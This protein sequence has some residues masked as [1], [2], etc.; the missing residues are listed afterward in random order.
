M[1]EEF[2]DLVFNDAGV[3]GYNGSIEDFKTLISTND[4]ALKVA[5]DIAKGKGY[6]DGPDSF[7]G[8]LGLE[9][10]RIQDI[11]ETQEVVEETTEESTDTTDEANTKKGLPK[12]ESRHMEMEEEVAIESLRKMYKGL[13]YTFEQT[14]GLPSVFGT[15]RGFTG[16]GWIPGS[17]YITVT[18]PPDA[19]G[20]TTSETFSFDIGVPIIG[21]SP[22][23]GSTKEA[24]RLNEWIESTL[25]R[26]DSVDKEAYSFAW[27]SAHGLEIEAKNEDGSTKSIDQLTA[28]EMDAHALEAYKHAVES[29]EIEQAVN[30]IRAELQPQMDEW[31]KNTLLP[32]LQDYFDLTTQ[33]GA[34][35][36]NKEWTNQYIAKF[37]ELLTEDGRIGKLQHSVKQAVASRFGPLIEEK[38]GEEQEYEAMGGTF[39]GRVLRDTPG[40]REVGK[41]FYS[42][43]AFTMPKS[44][45]DANALKIATHLEDISEEQ[46]YLQTQGY[47]NNEK[48]KYSKYGT[49]NLTT[50]YQND[51]EDLTINSSDNR[52]ITVGE[53]K[54]LLSR[55]SAWLS[56][57]LVERE[58][59][60]DYYQN[61]LDKMD[62][63]EIFGEGLSNPDL[64]YDDYL[65]M[66]GDQAV[67][68]VGAIV[69]VG[70]TTY[71][72]EAG[73]AYEEITRNKAIEKMFPGK[74]E[75]EQNALWSQLSNEDKIDAITQV[76]VSGDANLDYAVSVGATNAGLDMVGNS[77][78]L[79]S[80]KKFLPKD[81]TRKLLKKQYRE[82][83]KGGWRQVGKD[84]TT[85]SFA[86]FVTE[87]AQEA[88]SIMGVGGATGDFGNTYSNV[89]RM[90]EAGGQALLITPGFVG[91][92][93]TIST[94]I[95]E[96]KSTIS[97]MKDPE[98][99]R[100]YINKQKEQIDQDLKD[101]K[102]NQDTRDELFTQL[103]AAEQQ[104]NDTKLKDLEGDFKGQAIDN[105]VEQEKLNKENEKL[106]EDIKKSNKKKPKKEGDKATEEEIQLEKNKKKLEELEDDI[107]K[108]RKRNHYDNVEKVYAQ[109]INNDNQGRFKDKKMFTFKTRKQAEEW[110]KSVDK[111]GNSINSKNKG[112]TK[113]LY[114]SL[115]EQEIYNLIG[116]RNRNLANGMKKGNIA[117]V[118]DENVHR[119]IDK[120]RYNAPNVVHHEGLHFIFDTFTDKELVDMIE[121]TMEGIQNSTDPKMMEVALLM[122]NA[123]DFY[124][125]T[126][127]DLTTRVGKEEFF[128]ALS[129]AMR[130]I[131]LKDI[132]LD[133]GVLLSEIGDM[134]E[135]VFTKGTNAGL[136]FSLFDAENT[137]AFI[138]SYNSF[139]GKGSIVGDF[140]FSRAGKETD[141]EK[142]KREKD[143]GAMFS[144]TIEGRSKAVDVVNKIEQDIKQVVEA[145]GKEYTKDAFLG[146]GR[147]GF[148][149][150]FEALQPGGAIN[151]YIKSLQMS[152]EKTQKTIDAV[153]DRL[154][155]YDP[156][157]KRKDAADKTS[158]TIGEFLMA[159]V[160]YGK[161][162]AAKAL[163]KEGEKRK[164]TQRLDAK[165]KSGRTIAE[166]LPDTKEDAKPDTKRTKKPR[167]I[168]SLEDITIDNK[169]VISDNIEKKIN[170]LI[171]ENP[172]NLIE[173][174][175][176]LIS[177]DF[178]KEVKSQMGKIQKKGKDTIVS[179]EYKAHH[180]FNYD[181]YIDALD[182]NTIKNNYNQLFDIK[183]LRREK[184][185]KV[186]PITGKVTY[187]GKGIYDIS[188]PN[189]AEWTK[190]FT[191][192]GYTTLLARQKKLAEFIARDMTRRAINKAIAEKS[193]DLNQVILAEL[194]EWD[195]ALDKQKGETIS[196]DTVRFSDT[197]RNFNENE[198][199][200]FYQNLPSL[201]L[202][203]QKI[204]V[205][206]KEAVK[207]VVKDVYKEYYPTGKI[208]KM[209]DSIFKIVN[210][211]GAIE[212]RHANLKTKPQKTLNE[213]LFEEL[214]TIELSETLAEF[215]NLTD[216]KGKTLQLSKLFDELGRIKNG[217]AE[218]V[219]IGKNWV[220]RYGKERAL[221]ML[222][223]TSGM[224]ATSTKIGRGMFKVDKDGNV[225][226]VSPK[227][228]GRQSF[229]DQRYQFFE[230]KKDFNTWV[231][232]E[233]FGNEIQLTD[234]GR[235]KKI[236]EL[237][238]NG[239]KVKIDTSLLAETSKAAMS[240]KDYKARK[241]Q[242]KVS[243]Q[244]V[245]D[246]AQHYKDQI[247]K[248]KPALDK[249]DFAMMMMSMASNMQSPLKR[250]ANLGYIF[251]NKEGQK[252]TG[253]LRYE[254]MIPTNYMVMQITN[255]Y[256]NDGSVDLDA[257]FKEYTVAV[258][259][260]T[261]DDIFDAMGLTQTMNAGWRV[262]DSSTQRY[263]NMSTY[264]HPDLYAIESLNPADK[265][266][267]YGEAVANIMFSESISPGNQA[268]IDAIRASRLPK[269]PKGITV[270]DFDD[271]LA[272]TKSQVLFTAPD[273][274]KGKLTAEE[275]AKD[276]AKLLVE[277][278]T[279]DFSE[280]NQ[281]IDGKT[282]PLFKKALKL[283]SKFG[284]KNM[285]VLTARAPESAV[286]IKEFLDAQGLKIPLKN[287]TGLGNSTAD[288][289][290]AWI[291]EKVA[292]GYNDFYFAD[293]AIQNVKAVKN[294]LDQFDV[295]SK[296]QQA[297]VKFSESID[298][299]FNKILEE[300]TGIDA[301]KRFSDSKSRKRGKD[302]GKFR[303]F[304]PPSHEDFL[305]L[306]YNFMGKG[307]KGN[308][309]RDFF[310]KSLLKPLNRAFRELDVAK[311][312][313]AN[314]FKNLNKKF[315]KIK[316]NLKK[317]IP[318]G[319]FTFE[320]AI[321]VYLWDKHNHDI[322]GISKSDQKTLVEFVKSN[323]ELQAYADVLNKISK[324]D[325]YIAPTEGWE[326]GDIR[327][328]LDDATGRIGRK[329]FFEEFI[330]NADIIF[331]KENLNKIEAAFGK[332]V[333]EA[334]ED[335][336]HRIKTGQNR[337]SGS[338][339]LVNN[340]INFINGSVG[341]IMFLNMRSAI[342][343]QMSLVNFINFSDNN[344]LAA[345][346][347]FANQKQYWSDWAYIFNS[348]ML[349]QRRTGIKTDVNGAELAETISRSK[350]PMRILV[351]EL[352]RLGFTP[353]QIGDSIAIATG[354]AT[355]Y[356]NR[357]NS[358]MKDGL[359]QK[360]AEAKA[361]I[362]FQELA[363][364]TQQSARPDMVSQQQASPLGKFILAFQ[365]VTS[366]FNRL[367]KK[368]FLDIKNR[369]ISPGN[370]TQFQSDVSN[371]SRIAY[372]FAIQNLIFYMLQTALF[373][374][375]FDDD[376]D[377]ERMLKKKERA[378]NGS[379][380]SVL[381][382][383]GVWGAVIATLKNMG[384]KWHE[385]RDKPGY[386]KDEAAVLLE[387][388]NVSPPLGI[389]AR[390]IVNAEKTLN[391]NKKE[392][393]EMETFDID[394]PIWEASASYVQGV[395]NI[396]TSNLYRKTQ[397]VRDALNNK[398]SGFHRALMFSGWSKWNLGIDAED[399]DSSDTDQSKDKKK[400][401][402]KK[403]KKPGFGKSS[404][405]GF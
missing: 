2:L 48:L 225:Y 122:A 108:I 327:I 237:T 391:Y 232:K 372:Y 90:A 253:D 15:P 349:K 125:K 233:I 148:D 398:F 242:A 29:P 30:D 256:M 226:M 261:M 269:K 174:L 168:K 272:T 318:Q 359:S 54:A 339:A 154:I 14:G 191:E 31:A 324:Q 377:D 16:A 348:D 343:Q 390:K 209:A 238:I 315:P 171:E 257:L 301:E 43:A 107:F 135:S 47:D 21:G 236:Q 70:G 252:Y 61:L 276:G 25:D 20:N 298:F 150:I 146:S 378:I 112:K 287:I 277:G 68:I 175:E 10:G 370:K 244:V 351:R 313:I 192:G 397:N 109:H 193:N 53:R 375:M 87:T 189:K 322:P 117:V 177:K 381:R 270:L 89:K 22:F 246:I 49:G 81:L 363:E 300:I 319:D 63:P 66:F 218:I 206:D 400:T 361:W 190:Y 367:G 123:M 8:L 239:K 96:I 341:S 396:P 323:P 142:I 279:Y 60:S 250:A 120:G 159:N 264:G 227:D 24:N 357:V 139:N 155:N 178:A 358:Y 386:A 105:V 186:D 371:A 44:H 229:G 241:K 179:E 101:N 356:R 211:Y 12:V 387:M 208:N 127:R 393:E 243:E 210:R 164:V 50:Y 200:N 145:E 297:R 228:I 347:A 129:D 92:G 39:V 17:D 205:N 69:T 33:E 124:K 51:R 342:L 368:A 37:D 220:K 292:N 55:R 399:T 330:H 234:K 374:T 181:S 77:I 138:Q 106:E 295:K 93:K 405:P 248:P 336:L 137:L 172:D 103:E 153:T 180:A 222:V 345:S 202:A 57:Q 214:K 67:Q 388:L 291:A 259:P 42:T 328:D 249:E 310:E 143:E 325:S 76:V 346:K 394:N 149:K 182:V 304:I 196:F 275:F 340:F 240:D 166:T 45:H 141:E 254:H 316:K 299:D 72:Q 338:N 62:R 111:D 32:A 56:T 212:E 373:A 130:Y 266:K 268:L 40:L 333:R 321:R 255:A 78:I 52:K 383:T 9:S 3:N 85:A 305:G 251:K 290:A 289:K 326:A 245:K 364:A 296:V 204:N 314:D 131:E 382:G 207:Q 59:N 73:G 187:P 294:M 197:I 366:Q 11:E 26:N 379:I 293:D 144:E 86:E 88:T 38:Y 335:M 136:D 46:R 75:A 307:E 116:K 331:S 355:F 283:E 163:A 217:R 362:D 329:Q 36:A 308:S 173:Q 1:N 271:T 344:I 203:L 82:F 126:G 94:T 402:K 119:N 104:V 281:V 74:P 176:E 95:S 41:G 5:F 184:D 369:R 223:Q 231:V 273:G 195:A 185:K 80:G 183:Q 219:T 282:A 221:M 263:Y 13:G 286:A 235:L 285:F 158:V 247:M 354:G 64:S 4:K 7:S 128:T 18:S 337:A 360:E 169:E 404:K 334:F 99:T 65:R 216:D 134:F 114:D 278:Y 311:Q 199:T 170:D 288:A 110:M 113:S 35:E 230:N 213:Y 118:I 350:F 100:A 258:I 262:G 71:M 156:Q 303:F 83:L 320:D 23:G 380:D 365:N 403:S 309:H 162:V 160:G 352:L 102:I 84:I 34:D 151:N 267:V 188:K 389:K 194:R 79:K 165:D 6:K 198:L 353:T 121:G 306:L 302:K 280:F 385:Q 91:G 19:D 152:P 317:E 215:L 384:I 265:G 27:N 140:R 395:T 332:G 260:V 401:K 201:N 224:Y 274:T 157:A 58:V 98:S 161:L 392:I 376:E 167:K 28:E 312:S 115:S 147:K 133:N 97:G 284:T 132:N